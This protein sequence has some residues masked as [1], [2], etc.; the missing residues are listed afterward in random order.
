MTRSIADAIAYTF[1][2]DSELKS[3]FGGTVDVSIN[4]PQTEEEKPLD[5]FN[6][7]A[8]MVYNEGTESADGSKGMARELM[9]PDTLWTFAV[10]A[11]S[12]NLVDQIKRRM[13][14]IIQRTSCI[15]TPTRV[16]AGILYAGSVVAEETLRKQRNFPARVIAVQLSGNKRKIA[17][18]LQRIVVES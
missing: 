8:Y 3:L 10:I 2:N 1:Q 13:Q 17:L 9:L 16:C 12:D 7:T 6:K 15:E 11:F 4:W 18:D 14:E 5:K